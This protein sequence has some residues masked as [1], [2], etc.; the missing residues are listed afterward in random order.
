MTVALVLILVVMGAV[1][2]YQNIKSVNQET[3]NSQRIEQNN[4]KEFK[5]NISD[6]DIK[7]KFK[8]TEIISNN[9]PES[10]EFWTESF[11]PNGENDYEYDIPSGFEII[12][13]DCG[14]DEFLVNCNTRKMVKILAVAVQEVYIPLDVL[15]SNEKIHDYF[16]NEKDVFG[17]KLEPPYVIIGGVEDFKTKE[18]YTIFSDSRKV[19]L[20]N[21]KTGH[22]TYA[23]YG[24]EFPYIVIN[25]P[26]HLV[27][28]GPIFYKRIFSDSHQG[29]GY[30][31]R[32][33]IFIYDEKIRVCT[34]GTDEYEQGDTNG[35]GY[36]YV[37]EVNSDAYEDLD[38]DGNK[39]IVETKKKIVN[40]KVENS[41]ISIYKW[42]DEKINLVLLPKT[43]NLYG[44]IDN[45]K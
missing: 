23:K 16:I 9:L 10:I 8:A 14:K 39:E 22:M 11:C 31:L 4:N 5:N 7:K 17:E 37:E 2:V 26:I 44:D 15:Q 27:K 41:E 18:K 3:N 1:F 40:E 25:E 19:F 38:N 42:S 21:E 29:H 13:C 43:N 28:D 20:I 35:T 36:D 30:E 24:H 33:L 45:S 6:E 34:L 32:E 12:S